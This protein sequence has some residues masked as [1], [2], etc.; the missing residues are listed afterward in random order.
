MDHT[1]EGLLET[2]QRV[3]WRIDDIIGGEKR[4]DFSR[5]FLPETFARTTT[6]H[7][8]TAAERLKL[9]H[10]RSRGYLAMF[11]LVEQVIV[12]FVSEQAAEKRGDDPYE[13]RA[14]RQF[15]REEIKH[16]ELFRRF[17]AEF[18]EGFGVECSLIGPA[19]AIAD[20]VLSHGAMAVTIAVLGLEWMSQDHY[21]GSAEKDE[22]LDPQFKS[23]LRH[24][25]V[26][27]AQHAALDGLMLEAMADAATSADIDEAI[28][29][30]FE[31]G[32]FLDAGFRNQAELDLDAFQ[33]AAGRT[34]D[35]V[36]GD[37]FVREQHQALRWTFLGS[38]MRN[39]NFLAALGA[40]K[41]EA[42][43]RV[44]KASATF[45]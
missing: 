25:W 41:P 18:D 35:A 6:L 45:C 31:I 44:E 23:L 22:V 5:P 9:N 34:L 37:L 7:F 12:P 1:Y 20:A 14:L 33:R 42:R 4:L 3:N 11:E 40:L 17:L 28:D 30:Y 2:S 29:E 36:E 10:I 43:C 8:V 39:P 19:T 21:I 15:V 26:E 24:H 32:G 38:A 27:E 16:R 13:A